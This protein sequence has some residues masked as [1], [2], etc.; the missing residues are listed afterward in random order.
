LEVAG[1]D[2]Y[3]PDESGLSFRT[4]ANESKLIVSVILP[5]YVRN[6]LHLGVQS[7]G[8][9]MA[10]SGSGAFLGSIGLLRVAREHRLKFMGG[11]VL[12]IAVGV[13]LMS[14]SQGFLLTACAWE[15]LSC[16]SP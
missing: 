13:F 9:L 4:V 16:R 15:P 6:I 14:C 2:R 10:V 11:N 3:R 7:L 8:G 5:L 1:A 12:A